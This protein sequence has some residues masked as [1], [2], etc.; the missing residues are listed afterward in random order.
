MA[1]EA[2][3]DI[4]HPLRR[5]RV[6]KLDALIRWCR[7][8]LLDELLERLSHLAIFADGPAVGRRR[9]ARHGS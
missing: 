2:V 3:V 1:R 5:D 6:A 7:S 9:H 4:K 8:R